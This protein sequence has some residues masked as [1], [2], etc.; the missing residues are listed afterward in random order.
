MKECPD[1][2]KS[3][4]LNL[5]GIDWSK[6]N[7]DWEGICIVANSV[8]S[9]R[10]ARAATKAYVKQH[11]GLTLTDAEERGLAAPDQFDRTWRG[12]VQEALG[13]LGG[14]A[15]LHKIYDQVET[16]RKDAGR[17]VPRTLDAVVRRTLEDHS[18][19]S[20]NYKD[21]RPDLFLMPEG[22]GAGV[23]ALR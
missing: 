16:L 4:L 8:V 2:W 11:L 12:D 19:D 17:S 6:T 5:T 15:S 23:W 18:S 9:N 13:Q 7:S 1:D 21:G 10:Q 3:Q 22:P 20:A 14:T